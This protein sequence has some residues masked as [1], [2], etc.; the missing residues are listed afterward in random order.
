MIRMKKVKKIF[1]HS[2]LFL[3]VLMLF[4]VPAISLA[5]TSG[6]V[7][8]DNTP[9]ATGVIGQPC[10]FNALLALINAIVNF[11]LFSLALPIAAIMFAYAGFMLVTSGG[12]TEHRGLAKK[13][14]TNTVIG[15]IVAMAC[16]LIIKA[17]LTIL[18]YDG[19]WIG[20]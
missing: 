14:F 4:V 13:V 1:I 16:W 8:C 11:I 2:C 19:T 6:L 20:F 18:G 15:F 5:Q 10:N 3:I 17:I 12:S 7:P 9:N